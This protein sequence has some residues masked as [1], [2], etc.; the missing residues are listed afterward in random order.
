M[1]PVLAYLAL[2]HAQSVYKP[3]TATAFGALISVLSV[4]STTSTTADSTTSS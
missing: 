1:C 4:V 2:A 3:F